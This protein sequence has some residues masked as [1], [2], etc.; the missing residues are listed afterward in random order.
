MASAR[1]G[2]SEIAERLRATAED[3][4]ELVT[5]QVKLMRLELVGDA[6]NL[7]ARAV[8]VAMFLAV[9]VIGYGFAAAAGAWALGTLIGPGWSFALF[10]L[11][12]AALGGWGLARTARAFRQVKMLDRSRDELERSLK[13]VAPAPG[14]TVTPPEPRRRPILPASSGEPGEAASSSAPPADGRARG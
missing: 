9:A 6:R 3:L 12:H 13:A 2:K 4:M 14:E 10:G 5:A 7:G 8:R 11:V 1:D